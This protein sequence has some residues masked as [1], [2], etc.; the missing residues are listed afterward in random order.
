MLFRSRLSVLRN[1]RIYTKAELLDK[2][3]NSKTFSDGISGQNKY[4]RPHVYALLTGLHAD[5]PNSVSGMQFVSLRRN[6]GLA[7]EFVSAELSCS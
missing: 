5:V 7:V 6:S 2:N 1:R 3:E 4:V